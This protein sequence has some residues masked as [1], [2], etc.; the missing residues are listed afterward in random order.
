MF[1]GVYKCTHV[2]VEGQRSASSIILQVETESLF[3]TWNSFVHLRW[4]AS[5]R[6]DQ[7][8]S[9]FPRLASFIHSGEWTKVLVAAQALYGLGRLFSLS[10]ATCEMSKVRGISQVLPNYLNIFCKQDVSSALWAHERSCVWLGVTTTTATHMSRDLIC[11][12]D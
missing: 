9:T 10:E 5:S 6:R 3:L 4:L 2:H 12:G 7:H 11:P 8:I 1:M